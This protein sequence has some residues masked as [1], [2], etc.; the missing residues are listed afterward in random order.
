MS[1]WHRLKTLWRNLARKRV[2]EEELDAEIR[3][4]REILEDEKMRTG[5]DPSAARREALLEL[6]GAERIKEEV[7]D[8]R[9]GGT[10]E[11]IGAELRQSFR[12]LRRNPGLTFLGTV[13]LGLGMGASTLVFSIFQAALLK[14]LPFRAFGEPAPSHCATFQ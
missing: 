11:A 1:V 14:P 7:R 8:I 13:M 4:Y 2:V 3:S 6:G 10:L 12:G 9:L 5:A